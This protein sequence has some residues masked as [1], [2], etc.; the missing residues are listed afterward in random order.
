MSDL[1][2]QYREAKAAVTDHLVT[3]ADAESALHLWLKAKRGVPRHLLYDAQTGDPLDPELQSL[4]AAVADAE[5]AYQWCRGLVVAC[6]E[7][8]KGR[9]FDECVAS[10]GARPSVDEVLSKVETT[11]SD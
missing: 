10:Q 9:S 6:G 2:A 7:Q 11:A 4:E 8:V 3:W 5:A 1:G